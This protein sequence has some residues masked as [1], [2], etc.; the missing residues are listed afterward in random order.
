MIKIQRREGNNEDSKKKN[1]KL[2]AYQPSSRLIFVIYF[3][4]LFLLS[5]FSFGPVFIFYF[6]ENLIL[7][8]FMIRIKRETTYIIYLFKFIF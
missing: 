6:Y 8:L 2:I 7:F 5:F 4:T 1:I 3:S